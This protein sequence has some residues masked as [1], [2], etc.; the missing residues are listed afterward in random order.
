ML[1]IH[2]ESMNIK[3]TEKDRCALPFSTHPLKNQAEYRPQRQVSIQPLRLKECTQHVESFISFHGGNEFTSNLHGMF[4]GGS[5]AKGLADTLSDTDLCLITSENHVKYYLEKLKSK[6]D[7]AQQV[8]RTE[9]EFPKNNKLDIR[10]ISLEV[11]QSKAQDFQSFSDISATNQDCLSN[12][13]DGIYLKSSL[14]IENL[15]EKIDFTYEHARTI[16]S[17]KLKYIKYYNLSKFLIRE[18]FFTYNEILGILYAAFCHIFYAVNG[19]LFRGYRSL[20]RFSQIYKIYPSAVISA[21]SDC[22]SSTSPVS[23]ENL[24][25]QLLGFT[26]E[27]EEN[28]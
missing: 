1:T 7:T 8:Y 3:R 13:E 17:E 9:V 14:N 16:V 26:K 28:F 20:S 12:F 10:L 11:L 5:L 18:D 15:V 4:I 25:I 24:F 2:S 27:I 19:K 6:Y 23:N 21:F 22:Y